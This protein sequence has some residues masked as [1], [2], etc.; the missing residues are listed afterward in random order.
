MALSELLVQGVQL[1]VLGMGT[2]FI[3]LSVLILGINIMARLAPADD[4]NSH[5]SKYQSVP[6]PEPSAGVS[7]SHRQA[8]TQAIQRHRAKFSR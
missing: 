6:S 8:I 2:V 4:P 7:N 3:I 5:A 1:A